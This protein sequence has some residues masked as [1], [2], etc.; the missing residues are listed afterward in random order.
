MKRSFFTLSALAFLFF[1][2][3]CS[4]PKQQNDASSSSTP[5]TVLSLNNGAKWIVDSITVGNY[6]SLRTMTNMFAVAPYPS[7]AN[8]QV[9]GTDMSKGLNKM[10]G[11]CKMKGADHE[12]LHKWL[13]P[14]IEQSNQLKNIAD[15][16][17]ARVAFNAVHKRVDVFYDYFVTAQ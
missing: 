8:Y 12:A 13:A 9:Y 15:T 17:E 16:L 7:L 6:V 5:D 14:I 1:E 4:Q 3:S 2:V 10:L 11:E